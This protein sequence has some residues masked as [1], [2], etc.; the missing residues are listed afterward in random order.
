M[1][2]EP[3]EVNLLNLT[4]DNDTMAWLSALGL[5]AAPACDIKDI[6]GLLIA[7][8]PAFTALAD[9]TRKRLEASEGGTTTLDFYLHFNAKMVNL[10]TVLFVWD[11]T[12][13]VQRLSADEDEVRNNLLRILDELESRF[14]SWKINEVGSACR[15]LGLERRKE[16]YPK[17]RALRRILPEDDNPGEELVSTLTAII[18]IDN[19]RAGKRGR[20]L[21]N[22]DQAL[23]FFY[24]LQPFGAESDSSCPIRFSDY[25][26]KHVW[27]F[28][29]TLFEV[30][31]KNWCCQCPSSP[32]HVGRK[33][34]LNLTHYQRFETAPTKGQVLRNS[35]ALFRIL[36]P[37]TSSRNTEWQD[38][39][40]AVQDRE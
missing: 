19:K 13:R 26:L 1:R 7:V 22:L 16:T 39:E 30:I 3:A 27:K 36:F 38:T 40:I 35:R 4:L 32:S 34:R 9:S 15:R 20:L 6:Y 5:G 12:E 29:K 31:Q 10:H 17:L 18:R 28:T 23:G 37:T 21:Q 33:T 8:L 24:S 14:L 2:P 11:P 25:P